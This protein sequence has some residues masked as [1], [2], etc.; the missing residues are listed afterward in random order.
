MYATLSYSKLII[1]EIQ[2]Y[3]PEIVAIIIKGLEM[4]YKIGGKFMIMT[5]TLPQIYK[6]ELEK[7]VFI[8]SL[9]NL[10]KILKDIK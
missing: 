1:D 6:N 7:W 4:I 3:S 8:F 10:L 5:A 2:A 9:I